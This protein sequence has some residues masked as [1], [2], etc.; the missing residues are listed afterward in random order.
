MPFA[1]G[2]QKMGHLAFG[3][4]T[5]GQHCAVDTRDGSESAKPQT[6]QQ[7][8]NVCIDVRMAL[9]Y[10]HGLRGEERVVPGI[11][12]DAHSP[13]VCRQ[14]CSEA[15]GPDANR[16]VVDA[17]C[18]GGI[19]DAPR[20]PVFTTEV[21]GGAPHGQEQCVFADHFDH[22]RHIVE[23]PGQPVQRTIAT[24]RQHNNRDT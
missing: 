8:N 9:Q 22:W 19:D 11:G 6:E 24:V 3:S 15:A 4:E 13:A 1:T 2:G 23:C 20:H 18:N 10:G 12:H 14:T 16:N 5:V 17:D 7:R 21:P